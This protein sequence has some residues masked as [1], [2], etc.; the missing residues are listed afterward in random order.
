MKRLAI[1]ILI[2]IAS[3]SAMAACENEQDVPKANT[4]TCIL[5]VDGRT[6]ID[7]RCHVEISPDRH[8]YVMDDGKSQARVEVDGPHAYLQWKGDDLGEVKDNGWEVRSAD[9]PVCY[10]NH[11]ATMC[12]WNLMRCE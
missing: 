7:R 5:S 8:L 11:R 10:R 12:M 1:A 4:A 9:S 3:G 6:V 2:T